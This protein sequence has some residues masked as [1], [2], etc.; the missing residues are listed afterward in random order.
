MKQPNRN[1][2]PEQSVYPA[3]GLNTTS[4]SSQMDP[5]FSPDL[6]NI[7]LRRG[8]AFKR[9]GYVQLGGDLDGTVMAIIRFEI[10]EGVFKTVAITTTKQYVYDPGS[11]SWTNITLQTMGV[12]VDWTGSTTDLVDWVIGTD[13]SGTWLF[14]TNGKDEP[15][16]WDGSSAHF[17]LHGFNLVG[18]TT[19]KC[20]AVFEGSILLGNLNGEPRTIAWSDTENFTEFTTGNADAQLLTDGD[21]DI[22]RMLNL[23]DQLAVYCTNSIH[24]VT[25]TGGDLVYTIV[26]V[27]NNTRLLGALSIINIGPFHVY[28]S[29]E[30]I[31]LYDGTRQFRPLG[32]VVQK[33]Y[34]GDLYLTGAKLSH[35]F[36]DGI[37]TTG[38]LAL[39][40]VD[41]GIIVYTMEVDILNFY[42]PQNIRWSRYEFADT[43]RTFGYFTRDD[44]ILWSSPEFNV[45]WSSLSIP[46]N[47]N[48][49]K[50]GFPLVVF[51]GGSKVFVMNGSATDDDGAVISSFLDT[52]DF[53]VP[54]EYLSEYGRWMEVEMELR[55]TSVQ[56]QYS[57]DFGISWNNF[58]GSDKGYAGGTQVLTSSFQRYKFFLTVYAPSLRIR[59]SNNQSGGLFERRF[60]KVWVAPAGAW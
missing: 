33:A 18:F 52:V 34:R 59:L 29:E 23:A 3:M 44:T 37:E 14:V 60:L 35:A 24:S 48:S 2:L 10:S 32:D 41:G 25:F 15:R 6:L 57:T 38:L 17:V 45:P 1:F 9:N 5:G 8:D 11:S 53:T 4:P 21:G 13:D 49:A 58:G 26:K 50:Q 19:C 20:F 51:G 54:Q 30:N 16:K 28:M 56:V 12:D 47:D 40:T 22:V 46:W 43:P 55:G 39:S 31:Y 7:R 36:Y 27:V 42:F